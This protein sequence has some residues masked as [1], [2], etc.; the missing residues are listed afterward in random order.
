MR[1]GT[2]AGLPEIGKEVRLAE[3]ETRLG[4]LACQLG[5]PGDRGAGCPGLYLR[6]AGIGNRDASGLRP[7]RNRCV[8]AGRHRRRMRVR[9][10]HPVDQHC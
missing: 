1:Q 5:E 6:A 2:G 10:I 8:G 4:I 9:S 3:V 7:I